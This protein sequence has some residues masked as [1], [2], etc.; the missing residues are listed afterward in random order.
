MGMTRNLKKMMLFN[1]GQQYLGEANTVT[2][3]D[4]V[5]KIEEWRGAGM[6]GAVGMD[7]GVD[8]LMSLVST[9]GVPMRDILRQY[10]ATNVAG[11]YLR[12]AG[13]YQSQETGAADTIEI[14][15]RGRHTTIAFGDQQEGEVGEFSVTS[16]LAYYKLVWGGRTE[17]EYDPLNGIL[18]VDGV[19][20]EAE[21]RNAL[22]L[23]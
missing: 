6:P 4:L 11:V 22:G 5:R 7:M 23:F 8:G 20:I 18:I 1:E 2:L 12:F 3:P 19:D 9:F 10:G 16:T 15:M 13:F 14:I 17:I 21:A